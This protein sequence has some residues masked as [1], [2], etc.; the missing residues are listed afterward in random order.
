MSST[1]VPSPSSSPYY[2]SLKQPSSPPL[3]K[4][5]VVHIKRKKDGTIV[6]DCDVYIGRRIYMG[7]WKLND[8][9]W[10]NPYSLKDFNNDRQACCEAYYQYIMNKPELLYRLPELA[11]KRLG[12]WCT[13]E[14]CHGHVLQ[15]ILEYYYG[16]E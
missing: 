5:I 1:I 2:H 3:P 4:P 12:C 13:P 15:Y 9:I 11:G 8:S 7:G 14:L 10:H 6:Q 16:A